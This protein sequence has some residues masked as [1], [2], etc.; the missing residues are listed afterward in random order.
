MTNSTKVSQDFGD[1]ETRVFDAAWCHAATLGATHEFGTKIESEWRITYN[2]LIGAPLDTL[3]QETWA[4][5]GVPT[6]ESR[7][8]HEPESLQFG[9]P[10]G[11]I[12]TR[13]PP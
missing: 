1:K 11:H 9:S 8:S 6:A 4:P 13:M 5:T 3:V 10:F 7:N 12:F 2:Q